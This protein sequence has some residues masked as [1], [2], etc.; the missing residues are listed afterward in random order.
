[1]ELWRVKTQTSQYLFY[2]ITKETKIGQWK[3]LIFMQHQF[4]TKLIS[5]FVAILEGITVGKIN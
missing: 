2:K 3:V 5:L 1:M 4:T